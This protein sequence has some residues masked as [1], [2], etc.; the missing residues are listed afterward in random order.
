MNLGEVPE[1]NFFDRVKAGFKDRYSEGREDQRQAFYEARAMQ[2][3][4]AEGTRIATTLGTNPTF[5]TARDLTGTSDKIHREMR[6]SMGMALSPDRAARFGQV[7]GTLAND[8]TQDHSRGLWWLLNAPQATAN[9]INEVVLAKANPELFEHEDS[10][11]RMP[12]MEADE[13]GN[14]RPKKYRRVEDTKANMDA[15]RSAIEQELINRE[16]R[17]QKGVS[18]SKEGT[19]TRRKY[20]P[21][22]VAALAI[23][24]GIAINA[25]I[26]LLNPMG[27]SGGY[28]AAIPSDEDPAKTAN[29][30]LEV[31]AKYILGKTGN[32]LPY[33]EFSKHRP[34]VSREEYNAYQ[35]FKY[36]K[37]EDW[38]P[39][40]GDFTVLGGA[41][42]GTTDGIHGAELQF[43]GRS[44]PATTAGIPYATALAGTVAGAVA[45]RGRGKAAIGG[46]VGGMGGVS[47]GIAAGN[48]IEQERRRRNAAENLAE[49][50]NAE[51]YLG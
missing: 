40:D 42:K 50:G 51:M 9:V 20:A 35:A 36:D 49:G 43:L 46:L 21:G 2:G 7:A 34:D 32:L 11:V 28:A 29:P 16:G 1:G 45:G 48:I 38:N 39:T 19:L 37:D 12:R 15:Y 26:G 6:E 25:G 10:G 5:T 14:M 8:L 22:D 3:K 13:Y 44:L 47:L 31:G 17:R 27:G 30:I 4:D 24:S 23:P 33:D 41:L 18:M